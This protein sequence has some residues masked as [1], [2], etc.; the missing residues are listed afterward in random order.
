VAQTR[1]ADL[2]RLAPLLATT[3]AIESLYDPELP[4]HAAQDVAFEILST[5]CNLP[6]L[7]KELLALAALVRW[8]HRSRAREL[9]QFCVL[10]YKA[11]CARFAVLDRDPLGLISDLYAFAGG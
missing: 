4:R 5:L 9:F 2:R 3:K 11:R 10:E 8:L 6:T 1:R 7:D